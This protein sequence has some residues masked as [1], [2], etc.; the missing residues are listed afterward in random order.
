M[1]QMSQKSYT[2]IIPTH[3]RP[4]LLERALISVKNQTSEAEVEIIVVSD[5]ADTETDRVCNKL[6]SSSDMYIRRN[7]IPG[8]SASRNL[9]LK[10]STGKTILF[11]DDDDEW[12]HNLITDLE[13]CEVLQKGNSI[14][15]NCNVAKEVRTTD[16]FKTVSETFINLQSSL[17]ENIYVKNQ[18]PICCYAFPR[19]VLNDLYFDNH[20][21]AY[22]DWDFILSVINRQ[23]PIHQPILGCKIYEVD[24]IITDRR[25]SSP[26]ARDY[27]AVLDYLY[28]YRRHPANEAIQKKRAELLHQVGLSLPHNLF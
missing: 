7:G 22:E 1:N 5:Y 17:N 19:N 8:P 23:T 24:G 11:L 6:L 13:T 15:F 16:H 9:G 26:P 3:K 14:Y 20:M 4:R 18:I 27:N 21:R 10:N 28:V 25:G 2:V 12:T